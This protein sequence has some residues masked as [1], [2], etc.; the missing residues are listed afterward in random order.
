MDA[1]YI[2]RKSEKQQ[3]SNMGQ[4]QLR[5]YV[6]TNDYDDSSRERNLLR[7]V[8]EMFNQEY[9]GFKEDIK[10]EDKEIVTYNSR[11]EHGW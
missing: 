9:R 7:Y 4:V 5:L 3:R 1:I 10:A 11:L 8:E 6:E 2:L